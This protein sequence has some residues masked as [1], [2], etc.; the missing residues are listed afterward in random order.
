M[1]FMAYSQT[2]GIM[3]EVK[4]SDSLKNWDKIKCGCK[5]WPFNPKLKNKS[6]SPL[7]D[8]NFYKSR[9]LIFFKDKNSEISFTFIHD[10]IDYL[11]FTINQH[12][13]FRRKAVIFKGQ[14][15]RIEFSDSTYYEFKVP[16]I[17]NKKYVDMSMYNDMQIDEFT[18]ILTDSL[19]ALLLNKFAKGIW[20]NNQNSSDN[21]KDRYFV[22]YFADNTIINRFYCC[23][24]EQKKR[25]NIK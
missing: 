18:L 19:K 20:I 21:L 9:S 24:S 14:D 17:Y 6:N 25:Y 2:Q 8:S 15:F 11:H 13:S 7:F 23:F 5:C 4:R 1:P 10:S 3:D 22:S 12:Q 16:E